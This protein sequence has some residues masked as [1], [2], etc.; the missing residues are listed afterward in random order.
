MLKKGGGA[1]GGT[2]KNIKHRTK[3]QGTLS[4]HTKKTLGSGNL[5]AAVGLPDKEDLTEWLAANTVD[6][7]NELSLLYSLCLEDAGKFSKPGQGF[8]PLFEYRWADSSN[9]KPI[10]VSSPE[11]VDYVMTWVQDQVDNEEIFPVSESDP[12]PEDFIEG[13]LKDMFKRMFR[14]FA[15]IYHCHFKAIEEQEAA[16]HL[17][18]CFK[19]FVFFV[20]EFNLV[21]EKEFKALGTL[22]ERLKDEY[23][24]QAPADEAD[25]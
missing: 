11:Y 17:N 21:P 19:H 24:K 16:A 14:V 22:V 4:A 8:P 2:L 9:S 23:A 12:F 6:F 20:M 13:Y 10:Q 1:N 3:K 18:T 15:I 25:A 5:R 7:F